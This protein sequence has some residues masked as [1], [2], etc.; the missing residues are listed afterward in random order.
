MIKTSPT[1]Y[2]T[3]IVSL[4]GFI[5]GFDASVISGA[6]GFIGNDFQLSAWQQGFVVSSPTLGGIIATLTAGA[7]CDAYGRR[8]TLKIIAFLYLLSA[9]A[10]AFATDYWMLVTA[11]FIGGMAFCS[12]MIAP[13][14]IAEISL[15]ESRGKMVSVNQLNIVLGFSVSYFSNYY[16]LQLSQ[17]DL[18]WVSEWGIDSNVWRWMLG[19]EMVPALLWFVLLFTIPRSPRW[20]LLKGRDDE[21][22]TVLSKLFSEDRVKSELSTLNA[23]VDTHTEPLWTRLRFLFSKRMRFPIL[24]GLLVGISQQVTGINVI[25]FYAPTIFE[26]SG[27][28]TNAAFMQAVWI[29]IVNV[30]FTLVAMATIDKFGRKPLLLI[31]LTGVV[32]SMAICSWGFK[33]ATY[34]LNE[35]SIVSLS[36]TLE[37]QEV[38]SLKS[39]QDQTF[40]SDV[41]FKNTL[42]SLLGE[43]TFN[44]HQGEL[45]KLATKMNATLILAGI[46]GFV[47]SFA[48]S[49]GPVM[50]VLFSEIFPNHVRG[51]AISLV[52]VA[53]SA[54]SFLVQLVFPWELATLGAAFTFLVY[55]AMAFLGL[56]LVYLFLPETKGKS[57]EALE[58]SLTR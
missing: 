58:A 12:L 4:G 9:C 41:E 42:I 11:R 6:I 3:L 1:L 46:I 53:N 16:F 36:E 18:M 40:S 24:I 33:Q 56:I 14:Y 51:I 17:S 44:A 45:L 27:V 29:G 32:I 47:A 49:L 55:G 7:I 26:Q 35:T 5:F 34:T 39:I 50:W 54:V 15:P 43:K 28:G 25:F 20:L 30:V 48:M 57:L 23:N 38:T 2:Y 19:M 10:S 21:A 13:I 22:K 37:Q 31:G 52:G 8:K